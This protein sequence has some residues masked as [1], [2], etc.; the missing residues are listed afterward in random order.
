MIRPGGNAFGPAGD[1]LSALI[2]NMDTVAQ[3]VCVAAGSDGIVGQDGGMNIM[4]LLNGSEAS[5]KIQRRD[6]NDGLE[7]SA[8]RYSDP[9]GRVENADE[10]EFPGSN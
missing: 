1:R 7:M 9:Q 2:F 4:E 8:F 10:T 5:Y 3:E 6:S